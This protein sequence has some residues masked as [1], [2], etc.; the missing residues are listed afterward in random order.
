MAG[1]YSGRMD[2]DKTIP[3]LP[4]PLKK[5]AH[6]IRALNLTGDPS[7]ASPTDDHMFWQGLDKFKYLALEQA[8]RA[9]YDRDVAIDALWG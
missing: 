4:R 6:V 7:G 5:S 3:V 8:D 1:E 2:A 9:R